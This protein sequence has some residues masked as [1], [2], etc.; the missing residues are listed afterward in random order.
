MSDDTTTTTEAA[1]AEAPELV[2]DPA[3]RGFDFKAFHERNMEVR[4]HSDERA[5]AFFQDLKDLFQKYGLHH[6]IDVAPYFVDGGGGYAKLYDDMDVLS[7]MAGQMMRY[8][9]WPNLNLREEL[10]KIRERAKFF[11][12]MAKRHRRKAKEEGSASGA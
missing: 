11:L 10:Q 4:R 2:Q 5:R 12:E 1:T 8:P 9:G 6:D 7:D 3:D